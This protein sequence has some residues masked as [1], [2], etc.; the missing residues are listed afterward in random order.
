MKK[1]PVPLDAPSAD[2]VAAGLSRAEAR[3]RLRLS[4]PN[5][6]PQKPPPGLGMVLLRQFLSPLIFILGLAALA[7]LAL[8]DLKDAIF[9]ALVLA[10]NA[11][12]G[13]YQ[14]WKAERSAQAL[15]GLIKTRAVVI[16][17]GETEE[18]DAEGVVE[19][20]LLLL[21]SGGRVPADLK[22]VST[23]GLEIDESLLTGESMAVRKDAGWT[24]SDES[25]SPFALNM[26][27]AGSIVARGRGQGV[28]VATAERTKVGELALD[29][30]QDSGGSPPLVLRMERFAKF[31][32]VVVLVASLLLSVI[33]VWVQGYSV[34]EMFFFSIALAVSVIPEG[35]PVAMT[36]AL[37]V[38]TTRMAKKGVIVRKLPAVEGLGSCTFIASD[39]TGTLTCNELTVRQ[40]RFADGRALEV[41][42]EGF[43][44]SGEILLDGMPLGADGAKELEHLLR[45]S[46]L[47][48]EGALHRHED[49]WIWHGDPTDVALLALGHKGGSDKEHL[50]KRYPRLHEIPFEPEQ[51]YAATVHQVDSRVLVLAKGAPERIFAMCREPQPKAQ[52]AAEEMARSGHRVLALA[53]GELDGAAEALIEPLGLT[54]LGLVGMIDPLRGGAAQAVER[55]RQAG[56]IVAMVT[57]DHPVTALAIARELNLAENS[58]QVL[59]GSELAQTSPEKLVELITTVRVFARTSPRQKL[60]IVEAARRQGH[61]VA[62]TGDG[63][64]DAPAMRV[65]NIGVAMGRS[66]TDVAREAAD[67]VVSDDNF[68]TVVT[69]IEEGR[70]A[71]DNIRNVIYLLVSSGAAEVFLIGLAIGGGY[72]LP[73]LPVQLL[74]LNLVTNGLQDVGLAFEP[75]TEDQLSRPPRCPNERIFNRLMIERTLLT[76]LIM[77]GLGFLFYRWGLGQGWSQQQA[78][79]SLLLLLVLFEIAHVGNCRS[80]T[81]SAF[82]L[83]PLRNP[84]LVVGSLS[85]LGLHLLAMHTTAGQIVLELSPVDAS[86][87]PILL[88]LPLVLLLAEELYKIVWRFRMKREAENS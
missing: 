77:G 47:C 63:V 73:L 75:G 87:W 18:I 24:T 16:R 66:G 81:R 61:F 15:Q 68:A 19:G 9:I 76:S 34:T 10:V 71:Y 5:R 29:L 1:L 49:D 82:A 53:E 74:W 60:E 62:V 72:P 2:R 39:K 45:A 27:F 58:E 14:E 79:N 80:E 7:S 4:G 11:T 17:D 69:G 67:L 36:V 3:A 20:D 13:G 51:Q 40:L 31:V 56:I 42:G 52:Q 86:L 33:G 78:S 38:A 59:T 37:A 43:R 48:N 21:E 26:A 41:T 83:S 28:V 30:Q 54:L 12:L 65:A 32:A 57:G 44:P 23:H 6:L 70:V 50:L 84:F 85:A 55:C 64:N 8:G 88:G 46:V 25:Q 22:L 35:L